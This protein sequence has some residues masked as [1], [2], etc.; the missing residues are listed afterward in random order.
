MKLAVIGS[1]NFSDSH[2][3]TK[4][5]NL[6]HEEY[7]IATIVS[8]GAKGA[9]LM[10]QRWAEVRNIETEIYIP[11]WNLHGKSAGMIR[12][13]DI[14]NSADLVIAFWD[15]ISNGTRHSIDIAHSQKK[16]VLVYTNRELDKLLSRT[17]Y[18]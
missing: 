4:C 14:V 18:K 12:N 7:T 3:L 5:L 13:K 17:T 2:W 15:G 1:R 11:D 10:G 8:G 9:D 16:P 6:L